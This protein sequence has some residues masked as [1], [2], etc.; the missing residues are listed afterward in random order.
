MTSGSR[1]VELLPHR[2]A[3]IT[4]TLQR[5]D[6]VAVVTFDLKRLVGLLQC[7]FEF[8]E[9]PPLL[10]HFGGGLVQH[11]LLGR[12]LIPKVGIL[13]QK[14]YRRFVLRI[15]PFIL[16]FGFDIFVPKVRSQVHQLLAF[17]AAHFGFHSVGVQ[18]RAQKFAVRIPAVNGRL[19]FLQNE[20]VKIGQCPLNRACLFSVLLS[21]GREILTMACS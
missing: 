4:A 8:S 13:P 9:H 5:F 18:E 20:F 7:S 17:P 6:G 19:S 15:F 16:C 10:S 14:V 1:T 3:T 12:Q 2:T 21:W 11:S